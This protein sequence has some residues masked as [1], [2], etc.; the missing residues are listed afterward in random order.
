MVLVGK[1]SVPGPLLPLMQTD[2]QAIIWWC[3]M[4]V[5]SHEEIRP[6]AVAGAF[7][8][9]EPS[10][11]RSE[12][13]RL[14]RNATVHRDLK[15]IVGMLAP[16]AGYVYSGRVAAEAYRQLEGR[17][18][19]VVVIISPSHHEYFRGIS[20]F[21]GRGY[22]T[23]L[24]LV[25]V[26]LDLVERLAARDEFLAT[27]WAGHRS[28]HALEVQL[29]FLQVLFEDVQLVPVVMGDQ[30]YDLCSFLGRVLAEELRDDRALI[31][32]SSDLSHYY[33]YAEAVALDSRA[34]EF[35]RRF[36]ADG[37][38]EALE[39]RD[40]EACGGGPLVATMMACKMLGATHSKVLMYQNSGDVTGDRSAVVGYLSAAFYHEA[41]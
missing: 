7:Y 20:V 40:V 24:G 31:I 41:V 25:P 27:G 10:R 2:L 17:N 39:R 28:E 13:E 9:G 19:R 5:L 12:V 4:T 6:P 18:Y 23:P 36:D 35:V 33:T 37:L 29:P 21:A 8:P 38:A 32:A 14:L 26:D 34:K 16:H 3:T 1:G 22:E 11:L 15:E 30:S